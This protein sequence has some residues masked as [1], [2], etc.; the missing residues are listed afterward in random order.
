[1]SYNTIQIQDGISY[2]IFCE[3][4][5]DMLV[6][7][8]EAKKMIIEAKKNVP[9]NDEWI[10]CQP[11]V[12][13]LYSLSIHEIHECEFKN[14]VKK[15]TL[16]NAIIEI[17]DYDC[18]YHARIKCD[19]T[20]R[21]YLSIEKMANSTMEDLIMDLAAFFKARLGI[22]LLWKNFAV[23]VDF[24][25]DTSKSKTGSYHVIIPRISCCATVQKQLFNVFIRC[26]PKY[27]DRMDLSIYGNQWFRYPSQSRDRNP[28]RQH[29]VLLG[30]I[31]DF[32]IE[33][34]KD[35]QNITPALHQKVFFLM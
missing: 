33:N 18:G 35:T 24:A 25:A 8:H 14:I 4:I 9:V 2:K 12:F 21:I 16:E 19:E 22:S 27:K 20:Y 5:E 10:D 3:K 29:Y 1:M 15:M 28:K 11:Q 34:I 17:R 30:K 26:S 7:T 23:S 13:S 32:M 31:A 6:I